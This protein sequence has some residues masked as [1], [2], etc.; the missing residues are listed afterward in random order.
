MPG[1][2]APDQ[3]VTCVNVELSAARFNITLPILIKG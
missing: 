2:V 1:V 3:E